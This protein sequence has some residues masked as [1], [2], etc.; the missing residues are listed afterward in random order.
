MI[1]RKIIHLYMR[2]L[3]NIHLNYIALLE[4]ELI[5][6]MYTIYCDKSHII[7]NHKI[8]LFIVYNE[9]YFK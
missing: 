6:V 2:K 3:I 9:L 4:I 1:L 7:C 5:F 8:L